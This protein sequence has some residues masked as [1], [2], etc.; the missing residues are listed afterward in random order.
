MGGLIMLRDDM[1]STMA[2]IT[3]QVADRGGSVD[4]P[5]MDRILNGFGITRQKKHYKRMLVTTGYLY[6][7]APADRY[8]T[9]KESEASAT[10]TITVMPS[11]YADGVRRH[12]VSEVSRHAGI[13]EVGEVEL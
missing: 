6:F 9:T 3:R 12:I 4:V 1:S 2:Q 5:E 13:I 7:D 8:R 11:L 10:I